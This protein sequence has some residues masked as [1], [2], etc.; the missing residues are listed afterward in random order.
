VCRSCDVREKCLAYAIENQE[1]HG[2][3]GGTTAEQRK[4]LRGSRGLA[5]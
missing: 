2:I 4:R 1:V 5:S 3:W